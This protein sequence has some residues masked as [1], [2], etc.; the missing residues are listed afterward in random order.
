MLWLVSERD[1][2]QARKPSIAAPAAVMSNSVSAIWP[3]M[4]PVCKRLPLTLPVRRRVPVCIT[5]LIWG[6][7]D[8]SA[9]N[10]PKT[11]PH[12]TAKTTLKQRT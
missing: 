5:W 9:G 7:A 8:C 1:T 2:E 4:S 3:A 12:N 11:I 6:C 10:S